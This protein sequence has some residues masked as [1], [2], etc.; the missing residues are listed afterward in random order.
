MTCMN[1][2]ISDTNFPTYE[3]SVHV[4]FVVTW[5]ASVYLY[6]AYRGGSATCK[7]IGI[8]MQRTRSLIQI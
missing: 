4:S 2:L 3:I 6:S 7:Q 8:G 1:T 5:T